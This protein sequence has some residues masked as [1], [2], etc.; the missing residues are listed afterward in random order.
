M[1][2]ISTPRRVWKFALGARVEISVPLVVEMPVGARIVH[3]DYDPKIGLPAVWAEVKATEP[4][5]IRRL[6]VVM[7]G[8]MFDFAPYEPRHLGTVVTPTGF[9]MHI[10]EA[11][12]VDG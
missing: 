5:E 9:V 8:E 6:A 7:T 1:S 11:V 2:I 3:V 4:T 10:Y 12:G